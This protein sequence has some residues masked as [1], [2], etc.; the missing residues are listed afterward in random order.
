MVT[1]SGEINFRIVEK[2]FCLCSAVES[3]RRKLV[4]LWLC[5]RRQDRYALCT[6]R[7]IFLRRIF[8][9]VWDI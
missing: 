5:C 3:L 6:E 2:V 4:L 8:T 1:G 7:N 9:N